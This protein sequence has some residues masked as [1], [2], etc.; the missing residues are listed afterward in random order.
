VAHVPL[1]GTLA[2]MA[3]GAAFITI[4]T[5]TPQ[6]LQHVLHRPV[7]ST[8]LSFWPMVPGVI[9]SAFAL[10]MLLRTRWLPLLV[11]AGM[12]LLIAAGVLVMMT[13]GA[14]GPPLIP[15]AA[16]LGLGA[17]ATVAP[18][19]NLAAFALPSKIV[20]RVFALVELVRSV[21]DYLL[22]PLILAV[23]QTVSRGTTP[24]AHGIAEALGITLMATGAA[25]VFGIAL[26]LLGGT[27]LPKPDLHRWLKQN[28]PAIESPTLAESVR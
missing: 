28:Q 2:A 25:T 17:G 21:A 16:M 10:G 23:A 1:T 9:V 4:L 27:R 15:A 7:L 13:A 6:L 5:L 14:P 11:L 20:G 19:L 18:G 8:G 24:N 12:L 26:H 3:G 22:A